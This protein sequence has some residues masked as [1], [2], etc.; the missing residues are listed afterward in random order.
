MRGPAGWL[1]GPFRC[2]RSFSL[3]DYSVVVL[4]ICAVGG[5]LNINPLVIIII[6]MERRGVTLQLLYFWG[7]RRG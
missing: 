3:L 2:A 1:P 7:E 4:V 6:K 5:S